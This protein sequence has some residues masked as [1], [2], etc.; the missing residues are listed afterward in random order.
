MSAPISLLLAPYTVLDVPLNWLLDPVIV[1]DESFVT[2][3]VFCWL[4]IIVLNLDLSANKASS[5][6]CLSFK[7]PILNAKGELVD[8]V[9]IV[10]V[11]DFWGWDSAVISFWGWD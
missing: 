7:P 5:E 3:L 4:A 10:V 6:A 8:V 1:F 9:D 11:I 2:V